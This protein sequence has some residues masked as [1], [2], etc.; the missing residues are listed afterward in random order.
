[1]H[2]YNEAWNV[3]QSYNAED[4]ENENTSAMNLYPASKTI[5][6]RLASLSTAIRIES[7]DFF[8]TEA[9]GAVAFQSA[10]GARTDEMKMES[11]IK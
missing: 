8:P 7:Y 5:C 3:L 4:E 1:M 10:Q 9:S 2:G 6:A 11:F